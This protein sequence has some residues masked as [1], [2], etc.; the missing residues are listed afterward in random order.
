L[1]EYGEVFLSLQR[2]FA[3]VPQGEYEYQYKED[4]AQRSTATSSYQDFRSS[5]TPRY[6]PTPDT[7]YGESAYGTFP[8]TPDYTTRTLEDTTAG[9]GNLALEKGKE[10]E[11]GIY[12]ILAHST[13]LSWSFQGY[14][15]SV[16]TSYAAPSSLAPVVHT[17]SSVIDSS[18][19]AGSTN[20]YGSQYTENTGA[21]SYQHSPYPYAGQYSQNSDS[22]QSQQPIFSGQTANQTSFAEQSKN[23]IGPATRG[24]ENPLDSRKYPRF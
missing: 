21:S 16:S 23:H 3:D 22:S 9:I 4:S 7:T 24:L 15:A 20:I 12:L 1:D 5:E 13:Y 17:A 18:Y 2:K 8:V 14:V 10:P 19:C 6:A 11:A